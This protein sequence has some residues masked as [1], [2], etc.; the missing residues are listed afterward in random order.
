MILV[1][2]E[3]TPNPEVYKFV[4]NQKLHTIPGLQVMASE[5]EKPAGLVK[6]LFR[7]P[8]ARL[9]IAGDYVA[10]EKKPHADWSLLASQIR[11]TLRNWLGAGKP[12]FE[13]EPPVSDSAMLTE[14]EQQVNSWLLHTIVTATNLDGGAMKVSGIEGTTLK[15]QAIGACK[16]CPYVQETLQ[17][18]VLP[19]LQ[20]QYPDLTT[21]VLDE[22]C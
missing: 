18:G 7:Y 10:V 15:I 3:S 5:A 11:Q 1:Q 12:V 4:T 22:S 16:G 17:R 14:F 19:Q 8:I 13:E 2:T 6:D 9:Y 20:S 21:V